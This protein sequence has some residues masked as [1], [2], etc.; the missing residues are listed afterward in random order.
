VWVRVE[1]NVLAGNHQ[2]LKLG[3][4]PF[5]SEPWNFNIISLLEE[6]EHINKMEI[7][8]NT[9]KQLNLSEITQPKFQP[10]ELD[11]QENKR[12]L[13]LPKDAYE[14]V[15]PLLLHHLD[16][17]KEDQEIADLLDVG[18]G[19]V[20]AWLKRSVQE[21]LVEKKKTKYVL[22]R[23]HQQLPLLKS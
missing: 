12:T 4:M 3:A 18:V 15:L 11:I 23:N 1:G 19:Q 21:K 17:L 5:P 9:P 7:Q 14:A 10:I 22:N 16:E 13:Q 6:A 8:E 2:L 20:R